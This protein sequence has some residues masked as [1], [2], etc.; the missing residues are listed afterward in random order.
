M[1]LLLTT[2]KLLQMQINA[3][4][5]KIII[6]VNLKLALIQYNLLVDKQIIIRR[7]I[8]HIVFHFSKVKINF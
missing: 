6:H 4:L 5:K 3:N 8:F 2:E 7:I 1:Q